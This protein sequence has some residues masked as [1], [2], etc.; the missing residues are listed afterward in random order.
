MS[1][2]DGLTTK[3]YDLE[4]GFYLAKNE[5]G[6]VLF[7]LKSSVKLRDECKLKPSTYKTAS[8][9]GRTASSH[10]FQGC[11]FKRVELDDIWEIL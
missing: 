3:W 5:N 7:Q 11:T 9:I 8:I 2:V 10:E 1:I 6:T 4:D